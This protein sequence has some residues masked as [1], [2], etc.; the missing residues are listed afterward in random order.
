M[1]CLYVFRKSALKY[2]PSIART[3]T[4]RILRLSKR[5]KETKISTDFLRYVYETT[6]VSWNSLYWNE[7]KKLM[8]LKLYK[9]KNT[10]VFDQLDYFQALFSYK[11][12]S[13][14]VFRNLFW[15]YTSMYNHVRLFDCISVTLYFGFLL[16]IQLPTKLKVFTD[17][18]KSVCSK[19]SF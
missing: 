13:C 15:T 8:R 18:T 12:H 1:H 14:F 17:W 5:L 2:M 19:Q 3:L 4:K 16:H 6:L 9:S 7:V 11:W 10:N